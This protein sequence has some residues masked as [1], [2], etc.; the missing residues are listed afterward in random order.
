MLESLKLL[1]SAVHDFFAAGVARVVVLVALLMAMTVGLTACS[2][3]R[4]VFS[5]P[6]KTTAVRVVVTVSVMDLI[7]KHPEYK[8]RILAITQNVRSYVNAEPEAKAATVIELVDSQIDYAK[9]SPEDGLIIKS[10][11]V[12]VQSNLTQRIDNK[13]VDKDT[14]VA[15]GQ[16]LDWVEIAASN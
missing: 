6:E 11:L 15:V 2:T 5:D 14:L 8:P 13:V 12:A 4:G 1:G 16:I 3:L 9:L 10:M 7:A